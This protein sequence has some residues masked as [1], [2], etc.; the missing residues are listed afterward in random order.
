MNN[1]GLIG[2]L[3]LIAVLLVIGFFALRFFGVV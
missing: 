1:K 2:E 3:I